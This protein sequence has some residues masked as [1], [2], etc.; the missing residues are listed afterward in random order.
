VLDTYDPYVLRGALSVAPLPAASAI[1]GSSG[2]FSGGVTG[3]SAIAFVNQAQASFVPLLHAVDAH[4]RSAGWALS[5]V[6]NMAGPYKGGLWLLSGI[7]EDAFLSSKPF[8]SLLV[9]SL[10]QA[11]ANPSLVTTAAADFAAAGIAAQK[12]AAAAMVD[13][14]RSPHGFV[15]VG[16]A[17]N[18]SS[19]QKHLLY[20][21]DGSRY[22][23]L[24]G[25]YFRGMF[26]GAILLHSC[27]GQSKKCRILPLFVAIS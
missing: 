15:K 12:A 18:G 9:T 3:L 4:N 16:W 23:M 10:K 25:D 21:D 5:A 19:D 14:H 6:S 17:P 20:A 24:G 22:F 8:L 27:D 26:N 13:Y 11:A 2:S 1:G 7:A